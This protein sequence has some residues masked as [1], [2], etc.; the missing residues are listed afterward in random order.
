MSEAL[1]A[2]VKLKIT[3]PT[4]VLLECGGLDASLCT[5]EGERMMAFNMLTHALA[6]LAGV[7]PPLASDAMEAE[8][9]ERFASSEQ[10]P[11]DRSSGN[12][13]HLAERRGGQAPASTS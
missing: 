11:S 1:E 9:G 4:G 8:T 3:G 5:A 2:N 13:V 6:L 10:C 12:V 7:T